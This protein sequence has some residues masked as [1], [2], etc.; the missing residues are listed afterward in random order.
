[1]FF[2]GKG[3]G[4]FTIWGQIYGRFFGLL[5]NRVSPI[6]LFRRARFCSTSLNTFRS[7]G[8]GPSDL[9]RS[10]SFAILALIGGRFGGCST[11][12]LI[13][14]VSVYEDNFPTIGLGTYFGLCGL[15]L[16]G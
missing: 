10:S 14:C 9:T 3:L 12:L 4:L 6:T 16:I 2:G 8:L 1:M 7:Y 11:L 5:F 15:V 13:G